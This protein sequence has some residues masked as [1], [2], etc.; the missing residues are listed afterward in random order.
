LYFEFELLLDMTF[1]L[2]LQLSLLALWRWLKGRMPGQLLMAGLVTGLAAICRPTALVLAVIVGLWLPLMSGS[3][4]AR[5]KRM[6]LF[7]VGLALVIGPIFLR[8]LLVA[9]DPALIASQGGINFNIGNNELADGVS[10][11]LPEPLGLNWRQRQ[12]AGIAE[13]ASGRALKPSEVSSYWT[14]RTID[15]IADNPGRAASLF[16]KK[17]YYFLGDRE[18]SNNR[19]LRRFFVAMPLLQYNP[20]SFAILFG[21]GVMGIFVAWRSGDSRIKSLICLLLFYPPVVALFFF[22]S[23]FRLPIL[24]LLTVLA[25]VGALTV[26][27][28][29]ATEIKRG[30]IALGV[31]IVAWACSYYPIVN[32][33]K[34]SPNQD[35]I[36]RGIHFYVEQDYRQALQYFYTARMLDPS[37]PE[38]NLNIGACYLRLGQADSARF[39]FEQERS[40]HPERPKTYS[41]LASLHLVNRQFEQA[42]TQAGKALTLA[43][44]DANNNMIYLRSLAGLDSVATDILRTEIEKATTRTSNDLYLL[45][46]AAMLLL[47]RGD[48]LEAVSMLQRALHTEAPPI[49]TDDG[50][51]DRDFPNHYLRRLKEK[52]IS[53]YHLGLLAGLSGRYYLAI[54]HN[55][56]AIAADSGLIEAYLNLAGGHR[57]LGQFEI[58]DSI[59]TVA[60]RRFPDNELVRRTIQL[61]QP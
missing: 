32:L 1:T 43:H 31:V 26:L 39:Y 8:N 24:P 41:N 50:A 28:L 56:Q 29:F 14:W 23:R 2:T 13:E 53:H 21:F 20:I 57:L 60:N 16:M 19:E 10:S 11:Q 55:S 4:L 46:D 5:M 54:S 45:N 27:N 12:V 58:A 37:F 59:L 49:E 44:W 35:Y 51:F 30:F 47:G 22:N 48:T 9:D 15:W 25:A 42:A 7:A 3:A 18:V 36:S 17:L 33:P 52:A 61:R 6:A 38:T 40:L 34:G